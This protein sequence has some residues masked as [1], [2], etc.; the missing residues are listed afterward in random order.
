[1]LWGLVVGD[2]LGSP[3]QFTSKNG[4]RQISKMEPAI[5]V[6]G[7]NL[8][9][10]YWTDDSS[11]AFCIMESFIRCGRYDIADIANNFLRWYDDGFMSSV[12]GWSFDIGN[13]THNAMYGLRQGILKNGTDASQGNGSIMRFAPSFIIS[14]KQGNENACSEISDLTH[15]SDEVRKNIDT[16]RSF[17]NDCLNGTAVKP[18]SP[19]LSR[20]TVPNSGWA[21]ETLEAAFWGLARFD[22]F[23]DGM[24]AVVNLGGDSDSI[25]AVYGQLAGCFYGFNSIPAEWIHDVKDWQC[26]DD[27]IDSFLE[28]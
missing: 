7:R 28:K 4:H 15:N 5:G 24:L 12:P 25:G 9:K 27:L 19:H 22:S 21:K 13:A 3:I 6:Y 16:M 18:Q 11:M 8:P 20:E 17:C 23:K 26:I 2:C 10:G 1:M 14:L